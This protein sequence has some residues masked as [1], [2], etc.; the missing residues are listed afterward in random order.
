VAAA[1]DCGGSYS[2]DPVPGSLSGIDDLIGRAR[3]HLSDFLADIYLSP[4]V[5]VVQSAPQS[6]P[7]GDAE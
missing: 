2:A 4:A 5:H 3:D 7:D 1:L 6:S